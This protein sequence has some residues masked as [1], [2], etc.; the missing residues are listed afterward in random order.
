METG[1]VNHNPRLGEN[2]RVFGYP[3]ISAGGYYLTITDGLVSSLPDDGTIFTSAK[4]N[5][6]SSGGLAVDSNGCMLGVP[7]MISGDE[8]ESFGVLIS[9][10][11]VL[12]FLEKL[13]DFLE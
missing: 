2:V 9:N 5:H 8:N 13:D 3:E 1:C 10:D 6:G 4:I 12:E 11:V 7:S